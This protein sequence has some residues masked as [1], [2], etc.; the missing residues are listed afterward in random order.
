MQAQGA[1]MAGGYSQIIGALG[2]PRRMLEHAA[3]LGNEAV[4][5]HLRGAVLSHGH[6]FD[7]GLRHFWG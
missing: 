2:Y 6:S 5:V 4:T 1:I 3:K 7:M